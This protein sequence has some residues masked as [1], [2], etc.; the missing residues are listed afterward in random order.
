MSQPECKLAGTVDS[1]QL[2]HG[3]LPCEPLAMHCCSAAS[4]AILVRST[5]SSSAAVAAAAA[6]SSA[7]HAVTARCCS[8]PRPSSMLLQQAACA[9]LLHA[10]PQA[11]KPT[12]ACTIAP[13]FAA[14]AAVA[15]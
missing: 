1:S 15:A 6:S 8:V 14:A 3:A 2:K 13:C 10:C 11:A 9:P 7:E 5:P 4:A 12:T